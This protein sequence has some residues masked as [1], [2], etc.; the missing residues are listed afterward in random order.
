MS[1]V[2]HLLMTF[3]LFASVP[4]FAGATQQ[5]QTYKGEHQ[6]HKG[7]EL[8][9]IDFKIVREWT[10]QS[11][12]GENRLV[13]NPGNEFAVVRFGILKW[14]D[15]AWLHGP[16]GA[17]I[18][19]ELSFPDGTKVRSALAGLRAIQQIGK[20]GKL[21][22]LAT[23]KPDEALLSELYG[24][25]KCKELKWDRLE[26]PFVV[27]AGTT[28]LIAIRFGDVSFDLRNVDRAQK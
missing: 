12:G 8:A 17:L 10:A 1:N 19:L 6:T 15:N 22:T 24:D 18:S 25:A 28:R 20:D 2:T 4:F 11:F 14:E 3:V 23:P 13:A 16:A 5:P 7:M 26:I 9:V 21:E 27:P